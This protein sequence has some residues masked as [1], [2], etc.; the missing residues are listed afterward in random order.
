MVFHCI[1]AGIGWFGIG[2]SGV[3]KFCIHAL[4]GAQITIRDSLVP[5][6]NNDFETPGFSRTVNIGV[7]NK[8]KRSKTNKK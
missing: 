7:P 1:F 2:V 6:F 3:A 5:E 8:K 4:D